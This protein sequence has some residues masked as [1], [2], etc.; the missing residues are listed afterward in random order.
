[1]CYIKGLL[2]YNFDNQTKINILNVWK[3]IE[4]LTP[5]KCSSIERY[6]AEIQDHKNEL[7]EF[8]AGFDCEIQDKAYRIQ[9][10]PFKSHNFVP[11]PDKKISIIFWHAYMGYVDWQR[12]EQEIQKVVEKLCGEDNSYLKEWRAKSNKI[13][14]VV[15]FIMNQRHELDLNSITISSAAWALGKI[16]NPKFSEEKLEELL[17][18]D[19][20][21]AHLIHKIC[22]EL[23]ENYPNN[24]AIAYSADDHSHTYSTD[25]IDKNIQNN[26]QEKF[27]QNGHSINSESVNNA[28]I[29]MNMEKINY[30]TRRV[31]EEL[32]IPERFLLNY[33]DICIRKVIYKNT[34]GLKKIIDEV[35]QKFCYDISNI[36]SAPLD[37][38]N[39]FFIEEINLVKRHIN[40]LQNDSVINRYLGG[41]IKPKGRDVLENNEDFI[42]LQRPD[43]APLGRWPNAPERPLAALQAAAL[44]GILSTNAEDPY[45][46]KKCFAVN[47][48]PGTGKTTLLADLVANIY[49]ERAAELVKLDNP[50]D[51]FESEKHSI[52]V[53]NFTHHV[54]YLKQNLQGFEIVVASTNNNAVENISKELPLKSKVDDR[55]HDNLNLFGWLGDTEEIQNHQW[56]IFAAVLGNAHNCH[57]FNKNF[58]NAFDD[59]D[60]KRG[61]FYNQ[62]LRNYL[63]YFKNLQNDNEHHKDVVDNKIKH[64]IPECFKLER[65]NKYNKKF[66]DVMTQEWKCA[67]IE[68]NDI[69]KK[70]I[71]IHQAMCE[72]ITNH[73][74][75][76]N[77]EVFKYDQ[78]TQRDLQQRFDSIS[79]QRD[80]L[81]FKRDGLYYKI[82]NLRKNK[83]SYHYIHK[84]FQTQSYMNY[85][86]QLSDYYHSIQHYND[87]MNQLDTVYADIHQQFIENENHRDTLAK[88]KKCQQ[89]L[90][91]FMVCQLSLTITYDEFLSR[92]QLFNDDTASSQSNHRIDFHSTNLLALPELE[93]L[94]SKLFIIAVKIHELFIYANANAIWNNLNFFMHCLKNTQSANVQHV[95]AVWQSLFIIVPVISTTFHSL[96]RLLYSFDHESLGWLLIDEAGQV[97]PQYAV[98]SI[99]RA[100]NVV[101]M[102]DPQQTEP[103]SIL[104]RTMVNKLF[105][106][107]NL[108]EQEWSPAH[109]S[110]QNLADRNSF[111]QTQYGDD[112]HVGFPLL[113]HRRCQEPMFSICNALSYNHMMISAVNN[114]S[115]VLTNILGLSSWIHVHDFNVMQG[116][117]E[118]MAEINVLLEM[119]NHVIHK[120]SFEALNQIYIITLFK[121]YSLAVS[122]YLLEKLKQ[123]PQANIEVINAF[124]MNNIGTVHA[125][126]GRENDTVIFLLGAQCPGD[127]GTRNLMVG[128]PNI[129]NVAIS[130]AQR[131]IYIIGNEDIWLDHYNLQIIHHYLGE[132]QKLSL[133]K[134]PKAS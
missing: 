47:G 14:P 100:K 56:G 51:G 38:F 35:T 19:N 116:H 83:I 27:D 61:P 87:D 90:W 29:A 33:P 57:R 69:Q 37:M 45:Q 43:N 18:Y 17:N 96:G 70:I 112:I 117:Y 129:L 42:Y 2:M 125:F 106:K 108:N 91:D 123:L 119:I 71:T 111:Y 88:N 5:A 25:D 8:K 124:C 39:S 115:S 59:P 36:H 121:N 48:P 101:V 53:M 80:A 120:A 118:S 107:S 133:N 9:D 132:F 4:I 30:F 103:V 3:L 52:D 32:N 67:V 109:V 60:E 85:A 58:W 126:Q 23:Q 6:L 44:Q 105:K 11:N 1:M 92:L 49:V 22:T 40:V 41:G 28:K 110:V 73:Y 104:G 77:A 26:I 94:K 128:K 99:Y 93:N 65:L 76:K 12:A 98:G 75:I 13:V 82:E 34:K 122:Q 10:E 54:Q 127:K 55:Y 46:H 81:N 7:L 15:A 130:R 24:L 89:Q 66:A 95:R 97:V 50:Q 78:F 84:L 74:A 102:G 113:L 62:T 86:N 72:I 21:I 134:V 64:L 63:N 16:M 68:F 79:K 31:M 20:D 114:G 131:N